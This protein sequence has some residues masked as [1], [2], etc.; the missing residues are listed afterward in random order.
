MQ[1]VLP[2]I[3]QKSQSSV[4]ELLTTRPSSANAHVTILVSGFY[5]QK[6]PKQD[7]WA[8]LRQYYMGPQGM[9]ILKEYNAV[10]SLSWPALSFSDFNPFKAIKAGQKSLALGLLTIGLGVKDNYLQAESNAKLAGQL[11]ACLLVLR[12]PF[13]WQSVSLLGFSLGTSLIM[14][15]LETIDDIFR[16]HDHSLSPKSCIIKDVTLLGGTSDMSLK[17][18]HWNQVIQN[19]VNGDFKNVF[20]TK[21]YILWLP[22]KRFA[23]LF[24]HGFNPIGLSAQDISADQLP[25]PVLNVDVSS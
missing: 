8:K 13:G 5:T 14:S 2:Q 21:D 23:K 1:Q 20:S 9:D 15:C 12:K 6:E 4:L 24:N 10:Y 17:K 22:L 3:D 11:L 7:K 16:S 19:V 18:L 25:N